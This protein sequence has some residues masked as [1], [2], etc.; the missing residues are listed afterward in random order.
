MGQMHSEGLQN[1]KRRPERATACPRNPDQ[2]RAGADFSATQTRS[3]T[4]VFGPL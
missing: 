4:P 1:Q 2:V 3:P